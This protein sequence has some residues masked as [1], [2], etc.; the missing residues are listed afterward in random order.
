[1]RFLIWSYE[2]DAWWGPNGRGYVKDIEKAGRYHPVNAA[3]ILIDASV[4]K[5]D[6]IIIPEHLAVDKG[7]PKYHPYDGKLKDE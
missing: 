1:M 7:A 4:V 5:I 3:A 2:H 6:E